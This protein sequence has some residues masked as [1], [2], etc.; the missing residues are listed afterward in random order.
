MGW[1]VI[2]VWLYSS[3]RHFTGDH[4]EAAKGWLAMIVLLLCWGVKFL[5]MEMFL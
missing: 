5:F 4:E 2:C 1:L 3:F